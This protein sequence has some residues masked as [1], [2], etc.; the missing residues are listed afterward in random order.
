MKLMKTILI[1]FILIFIYRYICKYINTNNSNNT[2]YVDKPYYDIIEIPKFLTYEECDKIIEMSKG[3]MVSSEVFKH[4]EAV[5]D[6]TSRISEQCW[7]KNNDPFIKTISDK[8]KSYTNI[9]TNS[10]EDLQVVN[11]KAGGFFVPHYDAFIGNKSECER[12]NKYGQRYLT[13][14][15][16][17]NDT[18]EGGETI[19][20]KINKLIKPEK[21]KVVIFQNVDNNGAIIIQ[22]LHGGEPVK[23]GEKWIANK[24]IKL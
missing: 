6:N 11:Y 1:I 2:I 21:G 20:P 10:L 18:L 8:V 5:L 3:N 19:F 7:L 14:L 23:N 17:L 4:N 15:F 22:S 12:L 13:V 9:H 16:Y 24:W